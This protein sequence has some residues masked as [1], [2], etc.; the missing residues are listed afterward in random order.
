MNMILVT[1]LANQQVSLSTLT[2][3]KETP[4]SHWASREEQLFRRK[5]V[6]GSE[7]RLRACIG[8]TDDSKG[9]TE[10]RCSPKTKKRELMAPELIYRRRSAQ[11]NL[12]STES[13]QQGTG[14]WLVCRCLTAF[15][16][17]QTELKC[18]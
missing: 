6:S 16:H 11:F 8:H 17:N 4:V 14:V 10:I 3:L 13:S 5:S 1:S 15:T 7:T 2:S 12:D 18:F 9:K